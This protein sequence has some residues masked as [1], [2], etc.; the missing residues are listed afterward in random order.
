MHPKLILLIIVFF[1]KTGCAQLIIDTS[2]SANSLVKKVLT[3][4]S[5]NFIINN[6]A[7]SGAKTSIGYFEINSKYNT[8]INRGIII[9]TG[10][11]FDA[12]GPNTVPNKSSKSSNYGNSDLNHIVDAETFNAATLEFGFYSNTDSISFNFFFASEEYPEYVNKNVN[13]VFAFFLINNELG[14]HKNIA[15][16]PHGNIPVSIDNI[17]SITNSAYYIENKA[18][19]KNNI[20]KWADNMKQ[21]ELAYTFQ[22]DGLSTLLHVGSKVVPNKYYKLKLAIADVGDDNFDSAIFLEA[23]S[24]KNSGN[25]DKEQSLPISLIKNELGNDIIVDADSA[26]TIGFNIEFEFDSDKIIGIDS[27]RFLEKLY[28][29]LMYDKNLIIEVNGFT[30]NIGTKEYN[31]TLSEKRAKNIAEYLIA[32][33]INKNRIKPFGFG[34]SNPISNSNF[35]LNRRVEFRFIK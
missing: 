26:I 33:G 32:K 16:L 22:F 27:Y 15:V 7:Y 24:F 19:D 31:K 8:L 18:W 1:V 6:I 4:S 17:N 5:T 13:D 29:I 9:S 12:I 34:N 30:D 35:S 28:A 11:V 25:T 10:N 23:K 2:L 21:G 14:I 20:E 3:G